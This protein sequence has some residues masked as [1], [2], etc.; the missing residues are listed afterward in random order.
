M[1]SRW[2][3]SIPL[4]GSSSSRMVG[5]WT[6]APA[7][8]ARWRIP[9]EYVEIGRPAASVSSTVSIARVAAA[10]RIGQALETG[11]EDGEVET[12][13]EPVDRFALRDQPD[14][15]VH[16]GRAQAV[17]PSTRTLPAEGLSSPAIRWSSVDFPAPFG[18]SSPVTPEPSANEMSL[19][20][21]TLPYQRDTCSTARAGEAGRRRRA[22]ARWRS[23]TD[24]SAVGGHTVIFW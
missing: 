21:T 22:A 20:A 19:T 2:R 12:R 16:R 23:A 3:G 13:Q 17:F 10:T 9:F 8:F 15:G 7:S 5:S 18:P 1:W 24:P 14:A 4:K 6:S 11:V